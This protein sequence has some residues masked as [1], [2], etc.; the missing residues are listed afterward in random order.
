MS[1]AINLK[2][3]TTQ[4]IATCAKLGAEISAIEP[5]VS[6]GTRVVL[7]TSDGA[8]LIRRAF[9]DSIIEGPTRRTP[10]KMRG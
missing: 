1:R 8:A 3:T 4:I 6:G 9:K 5:L 2:S 10:S 7:N